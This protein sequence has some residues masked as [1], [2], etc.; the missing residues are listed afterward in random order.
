[1]LETVKEA[2]STRVTTDAFDARDVFATKADLLSTRS[3]LKEE[4]GA[5]RVEL[6]AFRAEFKEDIGT[7]RAEMHQMEA[8]L[9]RWMVGTILAGMVAA[10]TLASIID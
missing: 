6:L 1:M 7:L 4:I 2:G 5:V 10:A 9:T 8:R 3:E